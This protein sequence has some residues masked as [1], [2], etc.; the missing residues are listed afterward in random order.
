MK[1]NIDSKLE[2]KLKVL[3]LTQYEIKTF[4]LLVRSSALTAD[5]IHQQTNIPTPRIYDTIE[6]LEK[7][8]LVRTIPGRPKRFEALSPELALKNY[9][10]HKEK[11]YQ[12]EL[13]KISRISRDLISLLSQ[14]YYQSHFLIRPDDLLEAYTTLDEME[15][16]TIE[17]IDSASE[18]VSILTNVFYWFP[19]IKQPLV[20]ALKR[21]VKV[22]VLMQA[23][24]SEVQDLAYQLKRLGINV[25][26]IE[27]E[28]TLIRGTLVDREQ[29]I[30]VIW[31]SPK[32]HEKYVFRPHFSSNYGIVELFANNFEYLWEKA[33]AFSF[34]Y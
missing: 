19:K 9:L 18:E 4:L 22:R 20:A 34:R 6:S 8:G 7:K 21:G 31:A 11:E 28:V 14:Q 10:S 3:G 17:I 13:E 30:F 16:K 1:S 23:Q 33:K 5:N 2:D 27:K 26:I 32:N 25:R 29:V 12:N 15:Q 24:S